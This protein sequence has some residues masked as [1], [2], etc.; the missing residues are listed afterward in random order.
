MM[1]HGL[2]VLS[3]VA[4]LRLGGRGGEILGGATVVLGGAFQLLITGL[5]V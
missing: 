4:K 3:L 2:V 1:G 5:R